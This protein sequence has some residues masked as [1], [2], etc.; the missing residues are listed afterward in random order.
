MAGLSKIVCSP[1]F[2]RSVW[3]SL[4][5]W[6]YLTGQSRDYKPRPFVRHGVTYKSMKS[7]IS[8]R[9][10]TLSDVAFADS[11]RAV[12]GWNQTIEHWNRSLAFAPQGCFIAE[13]NGSR[14][15]T[16]T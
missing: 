13:W 14:A 12:T 16:A 7:E 8:L 4:S 1:G 9:P 6:Q 3:R 10:M 5:G 2:S 15:G 11:L